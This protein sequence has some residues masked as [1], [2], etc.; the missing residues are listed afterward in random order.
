[1][2]THMLKRSISPH[3]KM[4]LVLVGATSPNPFERT[5]LVA[6]TRPSGTRNNKHP[7]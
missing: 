3:E 6:A 5:I 7:F 2:G 1:V 4:L